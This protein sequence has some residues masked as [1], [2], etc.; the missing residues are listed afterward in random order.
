MIQY[1]SFVSVTINW[2]HRDEVGSCMRIKHV[3]PGVEA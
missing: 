2:M 1:K 3:V